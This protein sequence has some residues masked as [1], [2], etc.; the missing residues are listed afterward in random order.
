M[1]LVG[2]CRAGAA[3]G[4]KPC[5]GRDQTVRLLHAVNLAWWALSM[6]KWP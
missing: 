2:F 3:A 4:R 6:G 5:S 1:V